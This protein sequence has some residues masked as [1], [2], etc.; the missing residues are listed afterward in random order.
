MD[1]KDGRILNLIQSD[2][3]FVSCPYK[4][5]ADSLDIS[6]EELISRLKKLKEENIIRQIGPVFSSKN[7]GYR[8][9]LVAMKVP[10]DKMEK[11]VEI[12]NSYY[13]VT[14]NY[15]RDHRYN[16]WFTLISSSEKEIER[17]LEEIKVKTG[18][19]EIYNLPCEKLFKIKV[20]FA[21]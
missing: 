7:L 17:I 9:T 3:P 4:E 12:I 1:E 2:F 16:L 20:N 8:S 11:T 6:E 19:D 14:H 5:L 13:E 10:P 21:F 18:I 15:E